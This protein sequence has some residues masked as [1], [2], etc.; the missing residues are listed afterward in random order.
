MPFYSAAAIT[1]LSKAN[2]DAHNVTSQLTTSQLTNI[3]F[4]V[5]NDLKFETEKRF[6]VTFLQYIK[7]C[8]K[9]KALS[10][11]FHERDLDQHRK[12]T[13]SCQFNYEEVIF[14]SIYNV[15][16]LIKFIFKFIKLVMNL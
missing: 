6:K 4:D 10:E 16:E 5:T 8:T 9:L 7:C 1:P 11:V 14:S 15:L 3:E 2:I 13:G 12:P